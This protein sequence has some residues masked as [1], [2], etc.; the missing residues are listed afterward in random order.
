MTGRRRPQ[1]YIR[2]RS[3]NCTRGRERSHFAHAHNPGYPEVS[4]STVGVL[5]LDA[6]PLTPNGLEFHG[7]MTCSRAPFPS[8]LPIVSRSFAR[9]GPRRQGLGL[10]GVFATLRAVRNSERRRLQC[11]D[12]RTS[13]FWLATT[14]RKTSPENRHAKPSCSG[15]FGFLQS[16]RIPLVMVLAGIPEAL[17]PVGASTSRPVRAGPSVRAP[18]NRDRSTRNASEPWP[19]GI[20]GRW[21]SGSCSRRHWRTRSKPGRTCSSDYSA[22]SRADSTIYSLKYG[23]IPIVRATAGLR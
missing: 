23:T 19:R 21:R 10:E 8:W 16:P 15:F 3:R 4:R 9:R 7:N 11:L 1:S 6:G 14:G 20:R 12:S 17:R 2:R 22:T 18:G 13:C 5:G